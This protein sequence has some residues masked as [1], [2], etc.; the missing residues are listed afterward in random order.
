MQNIGEHLS[1]LNLLG[2]GCVYGVG[3]GDS[4]V[5]A[6]QLRILAALTED[7]GSVPSF[8]LGSSW[9]CALCIFSWKVNF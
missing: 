3:R 6:Q 1:I 4:G 2:V 7:Q 8:L 5:V 9:V